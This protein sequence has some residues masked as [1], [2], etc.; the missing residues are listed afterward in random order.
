MTKVCVA[1]Q[2][3]ENMNNK[4][5]ARKLVIGTCHQHS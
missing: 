3:Q 4:F 2:E 1:M 5:Q